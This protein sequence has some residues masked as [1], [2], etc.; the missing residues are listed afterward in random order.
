MPIITP[1]A[2]ISGIQIPGLA[3]G[4]DIIAGSLDCVL[5][6]FIEGASDTRSM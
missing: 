3:R 2:Q 5:E 4:I 6:M 1:L